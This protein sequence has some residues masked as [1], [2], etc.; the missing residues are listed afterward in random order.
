MTKAESPGFSSIFRCDPPEVQELAA[1]VV[2][3]DARTVARTLAIAPT[4]L[5]DDFMIHYI[6]CILSYGRRGDH[7]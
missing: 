1:A 3:E 5:E 7:Y 4:L 2:E 6:D